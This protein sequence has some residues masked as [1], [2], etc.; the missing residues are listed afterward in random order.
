VLQGR[1]AAL[2]AN[3]GMVSTGVTPAHA[4]KTAALVERSAFIVWGA[5]SL[6][7]HHDIPAEVN[8]GFQAIYGYLRTHPM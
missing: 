5:R 6:G 3:H 1:S 8:D 7:G 2:L 4:L